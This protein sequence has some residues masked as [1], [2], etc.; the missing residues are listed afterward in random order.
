MTVAKDDQVEILN[1]FGRDF[2]VKING[3]VGAKVSTT[4]DKANTY[5]DRVI[6]G[7]ARLEPLEAKTVKELNSGEKP[8]YLS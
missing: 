2:Y 6:R 7:L 3:V 4:R 5:A 1:P 8:P